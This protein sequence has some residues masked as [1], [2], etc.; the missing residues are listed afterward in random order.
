MN[1]NLLIQLLICVIGLLTAVV[2]YLIGKLIVKSNDYDNLVDLHG[3]LFKNN[4]DLIARLES[5]KKSNSAVDY[6][7]SLCHLAVELVKNTE[8][9]KNSKNK[10]AVH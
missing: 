5:L 6:Y 2:F 7:T 4:C 9:N 8:K 3:K 1:D 10:K